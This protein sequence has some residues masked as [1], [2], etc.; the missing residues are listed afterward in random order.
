MAQRRERA[1]QRHAEKLA[2]AQGQTSQGPTQDGGA[3]ETSPH[4]DEPRGTAFLKGLS[5]NYL[6]FL[7]NLVHC[8]SYFH[9][10]IVFINIVSIIRPD[11]HVHYFFST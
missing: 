6:T 8:P 10:V 9:F 7:L 11:I 4:E 2:A 3:L 5:G 1:R